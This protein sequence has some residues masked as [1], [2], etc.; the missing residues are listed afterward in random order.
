MRLIL[1]D[2]ADQVSD[3]ASKQI[4]AQ[5]QARHKPRPFVLGLPT[6]G[7]PLK[8]YARLITA[9][10]QQQIDFKNIITF[11][12]DEY[13]GLSADH[14]ASY[15]YYMQQHF[16][17]HID[18]PAEQTHLLNGITS[19]CEQTCQRYEDLIHQFGPINLM[20]GGLGVDGHLAFNEPGSPFDSRTRRVILS[21]ST[22][23]SNS[24]F[25]N[26]TI[27]QVPLA[28]LTIGLGTLLEAEKIIIVVT[29]E[30]KAKALR[31]ALEGPITATCPASCLQR[32]P[33]AWIICD[34][35]A[36]QQLSDSYIA[37]LPSH[38][39]LRG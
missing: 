18:I 2:T 4:I 27:S 35:A 17:K 30:N 14:P 19:D 24:R 16:F 26:N 37:S 11:N 8:I 10:Q 36:T 3:V 31:A 34:K 9:Y 33:N 6:G 32:H 39:V 28:A 5:Y 15:A 1:C 23:L 20:L 29:G 21:D 7:T 22:R 25:F 13:L 12:M 38:N